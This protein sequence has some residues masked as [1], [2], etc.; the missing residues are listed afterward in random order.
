MNS[1]PPEVQALDLLYEA[2]LDPGALDPAIASLGRAMGNRRAIVLSAPPD[3]VEGAE[4]VA[5]HCADGD[6]FDWFLYHYGAYYHQFDPTKFRWS[7][8]RE[9]EF[10]VEDRSLDPQAWSSG[11]FYQDFALA[12]GITGWAALKV[13]TARQPGDTHWALTFTRDGDAAA[14]SPEALA[15]MQSLAPHLRRALRLRDRMAELRELAGIGAAALDCCST[16][17]WLLEPDGRVRHANGAA[18]RHMASADAAVRVRQGRLQACAGDPG[19]WAALFSPDDG[20]AHGAAALRL[21]RPG[22]GWALAQRLPLA[23]HLPGAQPW[24]RP[25]CLLVLHDAAT[26]SPASW[27]E[28]LRQVYRYTPAEIRVAQ[29]LLGGATLAE[30]AERSEVRPATVRSQLKSMLAKSGCRRQA[31]LVGMLGALQGFGV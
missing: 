4:I 7:Q 26:A 16:P 14:F 23:P 24:Q 11:H 21:P 29:A 20:P 12:Q 10:M 17:L 2:V 30:I 1:P 13:A 25:L 18:G 9:G 8:A 22:G 5:T 15:R 28:V 31:E 3:L 19:R 27:A 6:S